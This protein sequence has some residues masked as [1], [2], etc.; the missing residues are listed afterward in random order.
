VKQKQ[1]KGF[2]LFTPERL[3][4]IALKGGQTVSKN[5][6]HMSNI[7]RLGGIKI[8]QD[9]EHMKRLSAKGLAARRAKA[10]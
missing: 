7:G 8:S 6:E 5:R 9:R 1:K 3:K 4:E 10:K 2:A